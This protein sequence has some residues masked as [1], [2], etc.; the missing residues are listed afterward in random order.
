[1]DE[2]IIN[3]IE[4]ENE[5]IQSSFD[6]KNIEIKSSFV[7]KVNKL[8]SKSN[9]FP[10][11]LN[12]CQN[13]SANN[14]ISH[15]FLTSLITNKTNM[16]EDEKVAEYPM[17]SLLMQKMHAKLS[18]NK[19]SHVQ[20][21]ID[22]QLQSSTNMKSHLKTL[23]KQL[24]I[25][26]RIAE[27]VYHQKI[28][29]EADKFQEKWKNYL[30]TNSVLNENNILFNIELKEL[31]K[32]RKEYEQEIY[33]N[34]MKCVQYLINLHEQ[35]KENQSNIQRV[36]AQQKLAF[37]IN[38]GNVDNGEFF[39][40]QKQMINRLKGLLQFTKIKEQTI[41]G[42]NIRYL[43]RSELLINKWFDLHVSNCDYCK[44]FVRDNILLDR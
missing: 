40:K 37:L 13:K 12:K 20:P 18:Q 6:L 33:E 25:R 3:L 1:M 9:A 14:S 35:K 5:I 17:F 11:L 27:Y 41:C 30:S 28:K 43:K 23:E 26:E 22:Q 38:C 31:L 24:H 15:Q 7:S 39:E 42:E 44:C 36:R 2:N 4:S 21:T 29:I 16:I 19:R 8:K 32:Q 10:T 34:K